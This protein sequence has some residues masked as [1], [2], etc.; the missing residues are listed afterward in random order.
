MTIGTVLVN[1]ASVAVAPTTPPCNG[2]ALSI[3]YGIEIFVTNGGTVGAV[4]VGGLGYAGASPV[5]TSLSVMA[6]ASLSR[7]SSVVIVGC[8]SQ[9]GYVLRKHSLFRIC[10][11]VPFAWQVGNKI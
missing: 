3:V 1:N 4:V 9:F 11:C 8:A 7:V 10:T 5:P 2:S 6:N